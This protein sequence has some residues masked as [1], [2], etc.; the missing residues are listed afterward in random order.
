MHDT[1]GN[2]CLKRPIPRLFLDSGPSTNK[3]HEKK[4]TAKIEIAEKNRAQRNTTPHKY[5]NIFIHN[6]FVSI[7]NL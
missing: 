1:T 2:V 3:K 7:F 5:E 4:K 6:I